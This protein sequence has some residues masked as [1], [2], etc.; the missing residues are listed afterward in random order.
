MKESIALRITAEQWSVLFRER[1][2]CFLLAARML[3]GDK[4][5]LEAVLSQT[6]V[7]VEGATVANGFEF[8]YAIRSL[9]IEALALARAMAM[10]PEPSEQFRSD[11][12]I[13]ARIEGLPG[14][15]RVVL[16]LRE[17]LEFSRRETS[18]LLKLSDENVDQLL[19]FAWK[20]L[21]DLE[22]HCLAPLKSRYSARRKQVD[23]DRL[24]TW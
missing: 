9:V 1:R 2:S 23:A 12:S 21:G 8:P 19:A 22:P 3:V 15:E 20:R 6:L 14:Q 13:E 5:S 17:V 4:C 18:L 16:F 11:R 24:M 7:S 10:Q